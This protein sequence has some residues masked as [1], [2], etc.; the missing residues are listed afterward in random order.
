M[1]WEMPQ[2]NIF[3]FLANHQP[4]G[5]SYEKTFQEVANN[6]ASE[7]ILHLFGGFCILGLDQVDH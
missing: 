1:I 5:G 6:R 4:L 3:C 7:G 2:C